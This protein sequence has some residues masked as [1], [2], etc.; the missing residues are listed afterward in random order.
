[1]VENLFSHPRT[2]QGQS[3]WKPYD[4]LFILAPPA[5]RGC[6]CKPACAESYSG[7]LT[8]NIYCICKVK[9]AVCCPWLHQRAQDDPTCPISSFPPEINALP[10]QPISNFP[11]SNKSCFF[12]PAQSAP[13]LVHILLICLEYL[14]VDRRCLPVSQDDLRQLNKNQA[15]SLTDT[16]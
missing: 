9:T 6:A 14:A 5:E 8:F 7:M 2:S 4:Y 3:R 12:S 16:R 10:Q 15:C 1:M 13:V 11:S